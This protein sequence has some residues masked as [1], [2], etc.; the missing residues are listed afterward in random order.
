MKKAFTMAEV[1]IT[2]GIIGVV[3]A[4]TLPSVLGKYKEKQ[5]VTQLKRFYNI[6]S[7]AFLLAIEE[8]GDF[9]YWGVVTTANNQASN[10]FKNRFIS[11]LKPYLHIIYKCDF[12]DSECEKDSY[13]IVSLDGTSH[14]VGGSNFTPHIVLNDGS[15]IV[16]LWFAGSDRGTPYGEVYVDL[17]GSKAPNKLGVDIF[18]FKI[19]G[20]KFVPYGLAEETTSTFKFENLCQ[21][22]KTNRMNGYGCAGWVLYIEN[23]DYLHCSGLSWT[24]KKSCKN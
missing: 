20:R 22:N 8:H 21:I 19:Q 9:D 16:H 17:N 7:N 18:V 14:V 23:M 15:T 5:T 24:G 4:M 2:I 6:M 10:D 13:S 12:G 11:Y 1:L 3:A